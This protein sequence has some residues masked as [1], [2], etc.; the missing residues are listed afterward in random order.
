MADRIQF[1]KSSS[2]GA[3]LFDFGSSL[4]MSKQRGS[5]LSSEETRK[6]V[7]KLEQEIDHKLSTYSNFTERIEQWTNEE[8]GPFVGGAAGKDTPTPLASLDEL[9]SLL[10]KL[11]D[12]NK[13]MN[14]S[15][16]NVSILNHHRSRLDDYYQEFRRLKGS[17]HQAWE[18]AQLMRGGKKYEP[19]PERSINIDTLIR[20]RGSIHSS[21][22]IAND[23]LSQ[24]QLTKEQLD[25][26]NRTLLGSNSKLRGVGRQL[27]SVNQIMGQI[28]NKK[29][30]NSIVLGT[31]AGI[32]ICFLLWYWIRSFG[33]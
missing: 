16:T 17:A 24:A 12:L 5:V 1:H 8:D 13:Q 22:N 30:R 2:A 19:L 25:M 23:L 4:E 28:R 20:E 14:E 27:P 32:C 3:D 6:D 29:N 11:T 18:R 7:K 33:R 10:E 31:V 26:Q 9:Q 15:N 21:S